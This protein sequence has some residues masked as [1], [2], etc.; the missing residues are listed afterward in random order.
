MEDC[1]GDTRFAVTGS[2]DSAEPL[3]E[4]AETTANAVLDA[5][6]LLER[7]DEALQEGDLGRYQRLVNQ[8]RA[9]LESA[10]E[11]ER[12]AIDD[13][14]SETDAG[15]TGAEPGAIGEDGTQA[16]SSDGTSPNN[17]DSDQGNTSS[18]EQNGDGAGT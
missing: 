8:A 5:Y 7:A 16:P 15:V 13:A 10:A 18:E 9:R 12:D 4:E 6:E 17:G 14:G 3:E 1:L 2:E 11:E